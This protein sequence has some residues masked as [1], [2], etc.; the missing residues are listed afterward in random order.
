MWVS[1]VPRQGGSRQSSKLV[2]VS[3]ARSGSSG[4]TDRS[5][6]GQVLQRGVCGDRRTVWVVW[7]LWSSE[8]K[9]LSS[10]KPWEG[11][12]KGNM[13][14]QRM[15]E[16][17]LPGSKVPL[18]PWKHRWPWNVIWFYFLKLHFLSF[19]LKSPNQM[20]ISIY[21]SICPYVCLAAF[22]FGNKLEDL[23]SH[24]I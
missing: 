9:Y 18:Q 6:W 5:V 22:W 17:D 24:L 11:R 8:E 19:Y 1:I 21:T 2:A 10:A 12:E 16:Q 20:I 3:R 13:A 7:G 4:M 23:S 15:L 14:C